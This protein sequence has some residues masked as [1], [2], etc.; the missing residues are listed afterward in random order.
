MTEEDLRAAIE[1]PARHAG[2]RLEPGLVDL[3]VREVDGEPGA[4]PLLSHA[5]RRTWEL[6]EGATLTVDGYRRSGGIRG[7]VAQSA[8][9]LYAA[10]DDRQRT[11]LRDMFLRLVSPGDESEA[12]RTRV[13]RSKLALDAAHEQLIE[14]LVD[15]RLLSSD[16]GDVQ[17]AHEALAREWPRL[18]GWLDEDVRAN[19]SS[20]TSP[21]RRRPGGDGPPASELYRGVRLAGAVDWAGRSSLELTETEREFLTQSRAESERELRAQKRSNRRLRL[22]LAGVAV[23]LVAALVAG[24]LAV[25]SAREV[26]PPGPA[27]RRRCAG[28]GLA[29]ALRAGARRDRARPRA[30]ARARGHPPRRLAR[31]HGRRCTRCW[32]RTP[33][34]S[35]TFAVGRCRRWSWGRMTAW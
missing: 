12:V 33:V 35:A 27:G 14:R 9:S 23:F 25:K 7:A 11:H 32:R 4:L 22:S 18:R 5:L 19:G 6:R 2:L 15:A 24:L 29:P 20:A 28:G 17:L 10:L 1:G 31:R 16:E 34:S 21:R 26:G 13:P 3:L 30:A 8:E